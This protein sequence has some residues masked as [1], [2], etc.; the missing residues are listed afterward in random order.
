MQWSPWKKRF[1]WLPKTVIVHQETGSMISYM[2]V[3]YIRRIWLKPYWE[4]RRITL[5]ELYEYDHAL[6]MSNI[7]REIDMHKHTMTGPGNLHKAMAW[8]RYL[9][10]Q[11]Y[12]HKVDWDWLY[13]PS[14]QDGYRK[15]EFWIRDPKLLTLLLLRDMKNDQ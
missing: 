10:S 9:K 7:L 3:L 2:R 8:A 14:Q 5:G 6:S 15:I 12:Q 11:G 1:A 13:H 4:R